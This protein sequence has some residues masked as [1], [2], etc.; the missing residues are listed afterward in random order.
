MQIDDQSKASTAVR[1]T[2]D[3]FLKFTKMIVALMK[4]YQMQNEDNVRQGDLVEKLVQHLITNGESN[5]SVEWSVEVSNKIHKIIEHLINK[6]GILMI[7]QDAL[8]KNDK[9]LGMDPNITM[10]N[11]SNLMGGE[12]R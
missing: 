8:S 7:T 2:Y 5:P 9:Y 4:D 12:S 6:E 10:E 11:L 1:L 3:E